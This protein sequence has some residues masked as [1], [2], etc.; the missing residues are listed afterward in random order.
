MLATLGHEL[1][2]PLASLRAT[3]ELLSQTEA[4][5]DL[6]ARLESGLGWLESLV[7]NLGTWALLEA[8]R[9]P[10]A[11]R[12][13][14]AATVAERALALVAPL[15]ERRGQRAELICARPGLLL[16]GDPQYLG[17]V[18]VNLLTNAVRYKI[19]RAHV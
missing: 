19:G 8:G 6:V 9:L 14:E 1:R 13:V 7:D 10:V 2:T 12:P 18:L 11:P 3:V 15:L 16:D 4:P 17:Q 5:S